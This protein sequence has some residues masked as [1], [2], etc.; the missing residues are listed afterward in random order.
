MIV[1]ITLAAGLSRRFGSDDKLLAPLW[2]QAVASYSA[3]A[4]LDAPFD[5]RVVV[6]SNPELIPIFQG[7]SVARPLLG[8][9]AQSQSLI[10]GVLMARDLGANHIVVSLVDMPL[11]TSADLVQISDM[12]RRFGGACAVMGAKRLP[13]AGF[14]WANFAALLSLSGD[15]G[16]GALLRGFGDESLI[17]LDPQRL[18]DIDVEADLIALGPY[19]SQSG[20]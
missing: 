17:A 15:Q 7:F 4:M 13:P 19:K 12:T 9:A 14:S 10:A 16:A 2:G 11:V 3:K 1:G 6:L 5:A 20:L 18:I 8:A